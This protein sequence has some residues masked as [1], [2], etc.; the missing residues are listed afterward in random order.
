MPVTGIARSPSP[1]AMPT[2]RSGFG[3]RLD[4]RGLFDGLPGRDLLKHLARRESAKT[5]GRVQIFGFADAVIGGDFSIS[6]LEMR[7]RLHA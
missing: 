3:R 5:Q 6:S 1:V 4:R 7:P 2:P